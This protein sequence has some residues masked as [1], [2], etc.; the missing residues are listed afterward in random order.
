MEIKE[1]E[2]KEKVEQDLKKVKELNELREKIKNNIVEF[3]YNNEQY[4]IRPLTDRDSRILS[5]EQEKYYSKLV[6]EGNFV[7]EEIYSTLPPARMA[8][9]VISGQIL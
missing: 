4:R 1:G 6:N 2:L 9:K 8:L 7:F 5:E 3:E